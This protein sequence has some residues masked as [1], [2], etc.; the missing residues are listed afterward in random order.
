MAMRRREFLGALG[1]LAAAGPR[2][3]RSQQ[4][5]IP[6]HWSGD[7]G[8]ANAPAGTAQY[9]NLL[10]GYIAR[11]PWHVAGVDY[12]VG[13]PAGTKFKD[14]ATISTDSSQPIFRAGKLIYL[15]GNRAILDSYDCGL[16]GGYSVQIV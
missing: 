12:A 15:N 5:A 1:G 10:K 7:D 13:P 8:S 14:P 3:A 2:V 11:P 16:G 4:P 9:P 6:S